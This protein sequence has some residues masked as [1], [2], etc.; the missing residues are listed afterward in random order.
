MDQWDLVVAMDAWAFDHHNSFLAVACCKAFAFVAVA[1]VVAVVVAV[2]VA[3]L[4]AVAWDIE[5]VVPVDLQSFVMTHLRPLT[6]VALAVENLPPKWIL[7]LVRLLRSSRDL[8][9]HDDDDDQ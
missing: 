6:S 4:V 8:N 1:V 5:A 3:V 7:L 9:Q 2:A